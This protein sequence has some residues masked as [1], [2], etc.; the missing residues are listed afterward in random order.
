MS[1]H[2]WCSDVARDT[3]IRAAEDAAA[4]ERPPLQEWLDLPDRV[5]RLEEQMAL[6][7]AAARLNASAAVTKSRS[8]DARTEETSQAVVHI[9]TEST[10]NEEQDHARLLAV[11]DDSG[12]GSRAVSADHAAGAAGGSS[13]ADRAAVSGLRTERVTLELTGRFD[14][15]PSAWPWEMIFNHDVRVTLEPGDSVRV[16][17][18]DEAD[19]EVERMRA[20]VDTV[21]ADA[22][23]KWTSMN[24]AICQLGEVTT[25]RDA[26]IRERDAAMASVAELKKQL[27]DGMEQCTITFHECGKGHGWLSATNWVQYPCPHCERD[28][29]KA[30]VALLEGAQRADDE[31]L[32][33]ACKTVWPDRDHDCDT[34]EWL[35]DEVLGLRARVAALEAKQA[36]HFADA[37]KMVDADAEPVAVASRAPDGYAYEYHSTFGNYTIRRFNGGESENGSK[38]I[39]AVPYWLDAPPPPRGWLT[40]E[41]R[42]AVEYFSRFCDTNVVPTDWDKMAAQLRSLLSRNSPPRVRMPADPECS[43]M[44]D[45]GRAWKECVDAVRAALKEAGVEVIE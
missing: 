32:R 5:A 34:P 44:A 23:A 21:K 43:T 28:A 19:A 6:A 8:A 12:C 18:S 38:P 39:R 37:S 14:I 35:A 25:E 13:A 2:P 22:V 31:R 36:D 7:H 15:P 45:Y 4:S 11:A 20:E 10:I 16:V 17:P 24:S 26:A 40:E 33:A 42:K 9:D 30:R 3:A 1:Q 27:P 41:E 29:L